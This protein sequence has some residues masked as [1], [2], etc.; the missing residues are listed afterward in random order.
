MELA[1]NGC[2]E[3]LELLRLKEVVEVGMLNSDMADP[4]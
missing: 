1:L 4:D 2:M 3:L